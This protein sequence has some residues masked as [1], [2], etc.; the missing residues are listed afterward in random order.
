MEGKKKL[1]FK[2]I[3]V[4]MFIV[5][6]S[7]IAKGTQIGVSEDTLSSYVGKWHPKMFYVVLPDLSLSFILPYEPDQSGFYNL[8]FISKESGEIL[9][10]D[11]IKDNRRYFNPLS[12]GN[13]YDVVLLYNNGKYV[14]HI[15]FIF[16]NSAEVDMSSQII[17]PSDS[18]SELWK[19]MRPFDEILN[20]I[21]SDK[22][23]VVES[24]F[25]IKGYVLSDVGYL[26]TT[27]WE[28][29]VKSSGANVK[30]KTCSIDGYFEIDIEDDTEQTLG[31][32][33]AGHLLNK[34]IN[35]TASCGLFLVMNGFG[36]ARKESQ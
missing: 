1:Y 6:N 29:N 15:D 5:T 35:I 32:T 3:L 31:V 20:A 36:R 9:L 24:N 26:W 13:A 2:L 16:E 18:D 14:R 23:D 22:E 28:P 30:R 17:K 11:T 10:L 12:S 33:A 19:T 8:F 7:M 27:D 25:I 4:M 34:E 21:D